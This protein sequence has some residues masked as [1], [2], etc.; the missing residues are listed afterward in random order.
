M[1]REPEP[2][3]NSLPSEDQVRSWIN[4]LE[5]LWSRGEKLIEISDVPGGSTVDPQD[6]SIKQ[7]P[8]LL[9]QDRDLINMQT[10][11]MDNF[12]INHIPVEPD[13]EE[14]TR[15]EVQEFHDAFPRRKNDLLENYRHFETDDQELKIKAIESITLKGLAEFAHT[16]FEGL[17]K[18][19]GG[20]IPGSDDQNSVQREA[21]YWER[22]STITK[23]AAEIKD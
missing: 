14:S 6:S 13:P 17:K 5:G 2:K 21:V 7:E 22:I 20:L 11:Y 16:R 12:L 1:S 9:T 3:S 4:E 8:T 23:G 18:D 19:S 10:H 15:E